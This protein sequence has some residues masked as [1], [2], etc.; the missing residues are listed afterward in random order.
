MVS[1]LRSFPELW[2][3]WGREMFET[4]PIE[5]MNAKLKRLVRL[6]IKARKRAYAPYS[7]YLVGAIVVDSRGKIFSGC[8][9]ENAN[10][11]GTICAEHVA[12][13][14]M[15]S[16]GSREIRRVVLVTSS[17]EPVFPCGFCRQVISEFGPKAVITTVNRRA[18]VFAEAEL[19]AIL[20]AGFS[21]KQLSS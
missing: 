2:V 8:N 7:K 19:S 14:K 20:P 5:K 3:P 9:V 12:V 16:R 15:V 6:A 21:R 10:Y 18:T 13:V 4:M 1:F 17:N 11:A